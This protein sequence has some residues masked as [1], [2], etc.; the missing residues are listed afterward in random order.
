MY[1]RH[2]SLTRYPFEPTVETDELFSNAGQKEAA[3][4]LQQL[5]DLRGGIGLLTGEPGCGKTTVCRQLFDTLHTGLYRP[6]YVSL[7]TGSILD[8][9][10][11]IADAFGLAFAR[12]RAQAF[13]T[14]RTDISKHVAESR[15][16]A[17][18]VID[19]AHFLRAE[20]LEELRLIT[21]FRMDSEYRMCLVLVGHTELRARLNRSVFESLRQRITARYHLGGLDNEEVTGYVEHRM[22][23]AGCEL[24]AFDQ[25][26]FEAIALASA[27]VP[28]RIDRIAH[29]SLSSAAIDGRHMVNV[30]DVQVAITEVGP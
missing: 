8:L 18:L 14:L 21:N 15:Q 27:G 24:P 10:N 12:N 5:M 6:R 28:R 30:D 1:Q 3:A 9:Y 2:F 11:V 29:L 19:E 20:S 26:A 16:I 4:R 17:V 23:L 13:L 25:Q 7:T 22:K